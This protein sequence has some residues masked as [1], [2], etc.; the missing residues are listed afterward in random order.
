MGSPCDDVASSATASEVSFSRSFVS[1][2]PLRQENYRRTYR[3][4][5]D[6]FF[7]FMNDALTGG[8]TS[9]DAARIYCEKKYGA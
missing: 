6:G 5:F 8:H 4:S 9:I 7:H 2:L 1:L 3:Y